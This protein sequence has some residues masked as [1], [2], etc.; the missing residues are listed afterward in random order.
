M[1][2]PHR[3]TRPHPDRTEPRRTWWPEGSQSAK[4]PTEPA[5]K[6]AASQASGPADRPRQ[7]AYDTVNGAYQLID[8]YLRQGQRMAES[9]WLPSE[10]EHAQRPEAAHVPNRLLRAMGD[11]TMAWLEMLQQSAPA[12]GARNPAPAGTAGPFSAGKSS[13]VATPRDSGAVAAHAGLTVCVQASRPVEVSVELT[14]QLEHPN[15]V[16]TEL[17]PPAPGAGP[18]SEI[19]VDVSQLEASSRVDIVVPEALSPGSYS[20]LL[21]DAETE[22]PCGT[23]YVR[24]I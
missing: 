1:S 5:P 8:E 4:P 3:R 15:L 6:D 12:P 20:G 18:S 17:R 14:R 19:T 22:R 13:P 16:A 24:V 2:A 11:M 23:V 9:I 10:G 7:T 21:L